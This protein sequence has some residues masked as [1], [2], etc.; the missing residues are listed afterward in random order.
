MHHDAV[1]LAVTTRL[2]GDD[3]FP[4]GLNDWRTL[5]HALAGLGTESA[6]QIEI[7]EWPDGLWSCVYG[8]R[9]GPVAVDLGNMTTDE[10]IAREL[11]KR[12]L[13]PQA[14]GGLSS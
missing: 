10:W 2:Q 8:L 1:M 11:S 6:Y 14:L 4:L 12:A 3:K 7:S 9:T 5:R 13:W